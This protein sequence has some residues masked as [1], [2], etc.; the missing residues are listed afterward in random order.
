MEFADLKIGDSRG[1][2]QMLGNVS[3][4]VV[5][6]D[7]QLEFIGDCGRTTE[8]WTV[9]CLTG[10]PCPIQEHIPSANPHVWSG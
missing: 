8:E 1:R 9:H 4:L 7:C 2:R 3:H 10:D 5:I 6:R